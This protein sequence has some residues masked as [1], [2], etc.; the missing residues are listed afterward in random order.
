MP[1]LTQYVSK[2]SLE[3]HDNIIDFDRDVGKVIN[4][5]FEDS[6]KADIALNSEDKAVPR[7][8]PVD[9]TIEYGTNGEEPPVRHIYKP[10]YLREEKE[11]SLESL[12]RRVE[13]KDSEPVVVK[14][15]PIKPDVE[16]ESKYQQPQLKRFDLPADTAR[17]ARITGGSKSVSNIEDIIQPSQAHSRTNSE[18]NGSRRRTGANSAGLERTVSDR[19]GLE[20]SSSERSERDRY[21]RVYDAPQ[22]RVSP[23]L[24]REKQYNRRSWNE[25]DLNRQSWTEYEHGLGPIYAEEEEIDSPISQR[26]RWK[27]RSLTPDLVSSLSS[28]HSAPLVS[29]HASLE[30]KK[31]P[32]LR[33]PSYTN[34]ILTHNRTQSVASE[35]VKDDMTGTLNTQLDDKTPWVLKKK[36]IQ[37]LQLDYML[38]KKALKALEERV[39]LF[40]KVH[41]QLDLNGIM[42]SKDA[43]TQVSSSETEPDELVANVAKRIDVLARNLETKEQPQSVEKQDQIVVSGSKKAIATKSTSKSRNTDSASEKVSHKPALIPEPIQSVLNIINNHRVLFILFVLVLLFA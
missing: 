3:E 38:V 6:T 33:S 22:Q 5:S 32:E 13:S 28:H 41:H 17:I 27:R 1:T 39:E 10:H 20:R 14:P 11:N 40:E 12:S 42:E 23:G 31:R 9:N 18:I 29:R 30:Q 35:E 24:Y 26:Q 37:E 21:E 2:M 43:S 19:I 25:Y 36:I 7:I 8:I 15:D 16:I 4:G 34:R